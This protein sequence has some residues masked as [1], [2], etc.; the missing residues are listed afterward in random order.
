M[1]N[2]PA[3]S[4]LRCSGTGI[5][6]A[7]TSNV[8]WA[9]SLVTGNSSSRIADAAIDDRSLCVEV[10]PAPEALRDARRGW[11]VGARERAVDDAS[12]D[13]TATRS[14]RHRVHVADQATTSERG[15]LAE[16]LKQ[17]SAAG[18]RTCILECLDEQLGGKPSVERVEVGLKARARHLDPMQE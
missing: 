6:R 16:L 14:L 5:E 13:V 18:A 10:L 12:D 17:G 11:I 9:P 15:D 4:A 8:P 3:A 2:T 1:L 7:G